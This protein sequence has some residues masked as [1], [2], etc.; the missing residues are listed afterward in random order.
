MNFPRLNNKFA[1]CGV[2]KQ[3]GIAAAEEDSRTPIFRGHRIDVREWG[4]LFGLSH[5]VE[6]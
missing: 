3:L 4:V 2:H 1:D 6:N 5:N